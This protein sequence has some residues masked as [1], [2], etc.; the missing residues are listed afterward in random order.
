MN[1]KYLVYLVIMGFLISHLGGAGW[2]FCFLVAL[3]DYLISP[4]LAGP[5]SPAPGHQS[6]KNPK[7]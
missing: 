7:V 4:F 2:G 6:D 1:I 3:V 5:V